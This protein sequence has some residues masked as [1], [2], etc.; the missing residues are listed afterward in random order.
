MTEYY[1]SQNPEVASDQ[2]QFTFDLLG[3]TLKFTTDNGVFS[4][5][6]VDYGSRVLIGTI[7]AQVLVAGPLLDL[8]CGYG[9]IGLSLAAQFPERQIVLSDVN[10]RALALA[11]KNAQDNQLTNVQVVESAGY[12]KLNQQFAGIWTNPPIRAGKE[13]VNDMLTAAKA[14]LLPGGQ[15]FA[16]LQKKQGAPSAKKLMQATF[17]NCEIIQRDKGYYILR[18]QN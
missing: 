1:Y 9:P 15:L 13:V 16:V 8:G 5:R 17:G 14:H 18:S 3:H 10:E 12:A 4:K 11:Q 6:T 7:P 2:Q